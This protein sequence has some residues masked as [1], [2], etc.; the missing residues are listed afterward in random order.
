MVIG[1]TGIALLHGHITVVTAPLDDYASTIRGG[2][3][4]VGMLSI[5]KRQDTVVGISG[6]R[7]IFKGKS[8]TRVGRF[9][10]RRNIGITARAGTRV[11]FIAAAVVYVGAASAAGGTPILFPCHTRSSVH[12]G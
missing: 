6:D 9:R 4:Q 5:A 11:E 2:E 7:P 1:K 8:A 10:R 3:I 12:F